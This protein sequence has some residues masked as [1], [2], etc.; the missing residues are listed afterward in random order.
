MLIRGKFFNNK[1]K[2]QC[3]KVFYKKGAPKDFSKFTGKHL[4]RGLV[5]NNLADCRPTTLLKKRIRY[6]CFPVNFENFSGT[7]TL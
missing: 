7:P 5:F 1:Q 4:C 6:S 2:N 3:P